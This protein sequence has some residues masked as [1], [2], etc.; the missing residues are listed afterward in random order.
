[1]P[2]VDPSRIQGLL[3]DV[4][5]TEELSSVDLQYRERVYQEQVNQAAHAA[6]R[7]ALLRIRKEQKDKEGTPEEAEIRERAFWAAV[8]MEI[9]EIRQALLIEFPEEEEA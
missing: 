3:V 9:E 8:E 7:A 5:A 4:G 2:V 6:A 1:M